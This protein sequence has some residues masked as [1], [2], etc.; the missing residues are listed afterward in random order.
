ME[1]TRDNQKCF[2]YATKAEKRSERRVKEGHE[3]EADEFKFAVDGFNGLRASLDLAQYHP[4][5]G[6]PLATL[7]HDARIDALKV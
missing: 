7:S 5:L 1:F 6:H 2:R 3:G 4:D